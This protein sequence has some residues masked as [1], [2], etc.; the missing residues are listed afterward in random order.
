MIFSIATSRFLVALTLLMF[1]ASS[2]GS[3]TANT[4]WPDYCKEDKYGSIKVKVADPKVCH[5]PAS[6]EYKKLTGDEVSLQECFN[7]D[8]QLPPDLQ[9]K[10][11]K[12]PYCNLSA[13]LEVKM[14]RAN[15]CHPPQSPYTLRYFNKVSLKKCIANGG[16]LPLVLQKRCAQDVVVDESATLASLDADRQLEETAANNAPFG[17]KF[18]PGFAV[19]HSSQHE[20]F[21]LSSNSILS[22]RESRTRLTPLLEAHYMWNIER[23]GLNSLVNR[24]GIFIAGL[25]DDIALGNEAPRWGIGYMIGLQDRSSRHPFNIGIGLLFESTVPELKAEFDLGMTIE[26]DAMIED[27]VSNTGDRTS[28]LIMLSVNL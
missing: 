12:F 4:E 17:F 24:H 22:K 9:A 26:G 18:G 19:I 13:E 2:V 1:C 8:G 25:L 28:V 11:P 15:I 10:C 16:R 23:S 27:M 20:Q 3:S 5:P 7:D 21:Y 14:S 6:P